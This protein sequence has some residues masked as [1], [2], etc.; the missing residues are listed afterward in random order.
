MASYKIYFLNFC[1]S[2]TS[3]LRVKKAAKLQNVITWAL[4]IKK[5]IFG[6]FSHVMASPP[7]VEHFRFFP[8][9]VCQLE[10]MYPP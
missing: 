3:L 6:G 1:Y 5:V 2:N 9:A 7:V 10:M 8:G 4:F